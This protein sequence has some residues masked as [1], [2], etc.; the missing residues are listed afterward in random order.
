MAKVLEKACSRFYWFGQCKDVEDWCQE[1]KTC[2]SWKSPS[3][4]PRAPMQA[5][6]AGNL[7]QRIAM[8]ILGPLPVTTNTSS[9]FGITSPNGR[10]LTQWQVWRLSQWCEC[11]RMS[12]S[13]DLVFLIISTR[14]KEEISNQPL[15]RKS[16]RFWELQRLEQH[17]TTYCRIVG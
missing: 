5:D 16:A 1:C 8:D 4:H 11:S 17:R 15:L 12:L 13:A 10:R 7:M 9:L 3:K 2:A 6:V 14:T